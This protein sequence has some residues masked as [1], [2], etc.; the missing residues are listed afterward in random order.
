M[1]TGK[2]P[3]HTFKRS[4]VNAVRYRNKDISYRTAVGYDGAVFGDMVTAMA[5]T[6]FY[7][8]GHELY[9][10]NNA[11][12]NCIAAGGAPFA[13]SLAVMLP[14]HSEES[15]L[16]AVM[17]S[18]SKRTEADNIDI[19]AGDTALV[20]TVS[21]PTIVITAY[22][23]R[24]W[25]NIPKSVKAGMDIVMTK[26]TGLYG[27]A[28]LADIKRDE[29]LIRYPTSYIDAAAAYM[30]QT[31]LLPELGVIEALL[32]TNDSFGGKISEDNYAGTDDDAKEDKPIHI[33]TAHDVSNGGV[34]GA[35]WQI[36]SACNMGV[37]IP[38]N[39]IPMKQEIIEICEFFNI[40][41]YMLNGQ[42][43]MLLIT[44]KGQA[45]ADRMKNSGINAVVLGKTVAG[46][47]RVVTIGE[48]ERFLVAPKGDM[49]GQ[50]MYGQ[51]VPV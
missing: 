30:D 50:V 21:E 19:I 46:K 2:L 37:S 1:R 6:A 45:L 15:T 14:E 10:Y 29:L 35:L 8:A 47:K 22:G 3:E 49:L 42:G 7:Y 40:N 13:V 9:A 31:S 34:F 36:L 17:D 27:G 33:F 11:I 28:V 18:L 5:T 39:V 16:R 12:N 23:R 24:L 26:W 43:S 44:D 48:E 4:V 41:P 25:E 51:Q 32:E 38:V 20:P